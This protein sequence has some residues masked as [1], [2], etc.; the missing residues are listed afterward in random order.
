MGQ[1]AKSHVWLERKCRRHVGVSHGTKTSAW[2]QL[3]HSKDNTRSDNFCSEKRLLFSIRSVFIT[4]TCFTF[5]Q[6]LKSSKRETTRS[7]THGST[8][9][10]K[11]QLIEY[12]L[13]EEASLDINYV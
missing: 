8:T 2:L 3:S 9:V 10:F 4:K 1:C 12:L 13:Q 6:I 7:H 11:N 5:L